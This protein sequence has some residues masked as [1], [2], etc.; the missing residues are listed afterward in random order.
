MDQWKERMRQ[1]WDERAR[2]DAMH[3]IMT[4]RSD[5]TLEEFL[6]S[7]ESD[8]ARFID[9]LL[10]QRKVGRER[11]LDV[12]C[13]I[14]RLAVPLARRFRHVD[15]VD[16]SEEMIRQARRLHAGVKN[17]NFLV[18]SG[19]D[20]DVCPPDHYDLVFSYIMLQHIPDPEIIYGYLREFGRVLCPGGWAFFQVPND[21]MSGHQKYLKRWQQRRETLDKEG[22]AVPFEDYDHP[23]LESKIRNFETIVQTPVKFERVVGALNHR[24]VRVDEAT[25]QGTQL[26]WVIAQKRKRA[27]S[28]IAAILSAARFLIGR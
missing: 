17:L 4:G 9:P 20:L 26:M 12:G 14:G 25:G 19:V 16:I 24:N 10:E 27:S 23:Y 15:G 22:R 7:G 28:P 11:A 3:Y 2:Q 21:S 18:G 8:V 5:W 13:G 1:D 6:R